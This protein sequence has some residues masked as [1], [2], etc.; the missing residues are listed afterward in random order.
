MKKNRNKKKRKGNWGFFLGG[1]AVS[2]YVFGG[3][4]SVVAG[5]SGF[6]WYIFGSNAIWHSFSAV[7]GTSFF[8]GADFDGSQ[9]CQIWR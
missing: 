5:I 1:T 9:Y 3:T 2:W 4:F 7:R 8:G 6:L